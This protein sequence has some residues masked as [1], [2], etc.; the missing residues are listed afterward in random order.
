MIP[1]SYLAEMAERSRKIGTE[2][3]FKISH[4]SESRGL[5]LKTNRVHGLFMSY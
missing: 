5:L 3:G 4:L 2:N 1:A